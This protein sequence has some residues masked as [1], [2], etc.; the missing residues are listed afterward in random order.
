LSVEQLLTH[1]LGSASAR[2]DRGADLDYQ[3]L[4]IIVHALAARTG[5]TVMSR[6]RRMTIAGGV[7]WLAD[8]LNPADGPKAFAAYV[9]QDSVLLPPGQA[10]YH[11]VKRWV[12][13]L[14]A[15]SRPWRTARR[16]CPACSAD[17]SRG[18]V[19][20]AALPLMISCAEHGCRLESIHEVR[21]A[22]RY[23]ESMTPHPVP[24][25]VAALD[26]LTFEGIATAAVTLPSRNR[27]ALSRHCPS[28]ALWFLGFN[29]CLPRL[30]EPPGS[31]SPGE[32]GRWLGQPR[33][34]VSSSRISATWSLI[35][36]LKVGSAA[37]VHRFRARAAR[38]ALAPWAPKDLVGIPPKQPDPDASPI[39]FQQKTGINTTETK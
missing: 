39:D 15:R 20:L 32:R 9:R 26:R 34:V 7:P 6:L 13:W 31:V 24:D 14:P 30:W 18:I 3:T 22:H 8:T 27:K 37:R 25:A 10:G 29:R 5:V 16:V 36:A 35:A 4:A 1:N 11:V 12:P 17:P 2:F 23:G 21:R 33:L 19:L 38:T 28:G